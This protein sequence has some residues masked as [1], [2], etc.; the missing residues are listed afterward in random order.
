MTRKILQILLFSYSV[1][2][3]GQGPKAPPAK[4]Q[5]I[6][7]IVVDQFRYDYLLRFRKDYTGGFKTLLEQGAVFDDAH[8]IHYPTVTAVGHS[9][10]MSG[11]TPSISGIVNNSWYDREL[12]K[13]VTSVSDETTTLVGGKPGTAGSSPRRL[14]VSTVGDEIKMAGQPAKVIGISIKDRGAILTSGHMADAAYWFDAASNQWTTSSYYMKQ[15]PAWAAKVNESHPDTRSLNQQWLPLDA[16]PGVPPFCTTAT[17]QPGVRKCESLEATP[18]GNE[19][20][21]ELAEKALAEEK[22]GQ[23][24][25]ATDVLTVSFSSNDYVGHALGPDSPEVRDISRRT[26]LLLGKLIAAA[27]KASGVGHVLFVLTADHGVSPVPEVNAARN[28]PGGRLVESTAL[29]AMQK[30]LTDKYGEGKWV[31]GNSGTTA[32]FDRALAQKYKVS[33][34]DVEQTAA[35]SVRTMPH[36]FRVYTAE[37][38]R[39]GRVTRDEISAA[40]TYGYYGARSGDIFIITEPYYLYDA[41]GTT[42]GTPFDY[43]SHVPLIF[44]GAGIHA[45][46]YY[47]KTAINDVAPTLAAIAGVEQPSG[48]VGRVLQEM[49]Q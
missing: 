33:L 47:Q 28:M 11:A 34:G 39:T 17:G 7:A 26:D 40:L 37:D 6:V 14:L 41:T 38:I 1:I 25:G 35:E 4:P 3:F 9:T 18:W 44:M 19:L 42:H 31:I 23:H 43:D 22:L 8:H 2:A 32:Y 48:S 15:L 49:W 21:E 46:H 20:I 27:N 36:I 24:P 45:G 10:F 16:K 5:L 30:A 12:K 29:S 13:T